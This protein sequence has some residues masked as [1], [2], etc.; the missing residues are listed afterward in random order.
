MDILELEF[1]RRFIRL[2]SDGWAQGWH[3]R[4][5]GNL[6][7][8]L[9]SEEA[10]V[11]KP[12]FDASRDWVPLNIQLNALAGEHFLVTGSGKYFRN[13]ELCPAS[14]IGIV[15]ISSSG[16]AYRIVWGLRNGAAPTSELPTHL[17]SHAVRKAATE[18]ANRVIYHAHPSA[19]IAMTYILPLT[20]GDFSRALWRSA[21]ECVMVFPR[22]VGVV[23]WMM[24][25]GAEI[26][27]A[28]GELMR[29]YSAAVWAQHGLFC[30]GANFD[31]CFGLMHTIEKAADIYLRVLS[32]G[33][34]ILQTVTD[35]KLRAIA[36]EFGAELNEE[37]L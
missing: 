8:R 28:T 32:A 15:E 34:P 22:G 12:F 2:C 4:N 21:T 1:M 24:P 11:C 5:G 7:Y 6:S 36:R 20:A 29:T 16:D 13:V 25:G 10:E 19:V 14:N 3:E 27:K 37:L 26:A 17:M 23:P 18:G 30:S 35:D 33:Q 31:E 9:K